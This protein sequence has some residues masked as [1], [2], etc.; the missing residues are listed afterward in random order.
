M[1]AFF[2]TCS[3]RACLAFHALRSVNASFLPS[4]H[5]TMHTA[6][7]QMQFTSRAKE[8][9]RKNKTKLKDSEHSTASIVEKITEIHLK[10]QLK[11]PGKKHT[12]FGSFKAISGQ[13][14]TSEQQ[15]T[16][17][18]LQLISKS[19]NLN[20]AVHSSRVLLS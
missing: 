14:I 10:Q 12:Y 1:I 18:T 6:Y 3:L 4:A 15:C 8:T 7:I 19:L 20:S 5:C 16:K 9:Y 13:I 2:S 11:I 17:I